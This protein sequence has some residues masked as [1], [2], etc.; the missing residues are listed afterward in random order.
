MKTDMFDISSCRD[1]FPILQDDKVAYLDSASSA[2]KPQAVLDAMTAL[3]SDHYANIHRGLYSFSQATTERFE[4]VRGKVAAFLNAPSDQEVV[5]TRNA[6]E[7]IN[8]V[9]HSWGR[10]HLKEGDEILLSAMEHHANI[11]PWQLLQAETGVIIK[12]IPVLDDGVLDMA[13]FERMLTP[14]TKL[15]SIVHISNALGTVNNINKI[16]E[17]VK[18]FYPEMKV[19]ID[20]SQGV[21]HGTVDVQALGCDFYVF[22][23]HKLYGPTGVGVLWGR[24]DV[25]ETMP[26]Y[27]GGG[28]MIETVSFDKTTFK[29]PPARFEAGTPAIMEVIGL[30]AAIDY[31]STIGM[32]AISA[33]EQSLLAYMQERLEA[34]DGLSFYGT[35]PDK[36]GIV[37]FTAAWGHPSDIGMILDQCGVAVRTG[38]H[39]CQPLMERFEIDAT[40][41]AS[42]GLYSN[43][44]DIDA[45]AAGLSKAKDMLS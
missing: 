43:T 30:G 26:P 18:D 25:L 3:A 37:S 23:G 4:A 24:Y 17:I 8:L 38:H 11:V 9:A 35:G 32:D 44:A 39:C 19:L 22:T 10:K 42:L 16:I 45:L 29:A 2:Q 36:T 28:D 41:R 27:Q 1:D 40:V 31:V 21:V 12:V 13:A 7:A 33:H 20:G 34:I 5:F 15:V 14:Q 6:T